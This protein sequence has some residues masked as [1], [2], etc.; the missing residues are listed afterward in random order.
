MQLTP[1]QF[2]PGIVRDATAYTNKGGWFDGNLVR[3]RLGFPE[4]IGGWKRLSGNAFL[5]SCRSMHV[6]FSLNNSRRFAFG[7]HRKYYIE[8]G[9]GLYDIT[10]VR[11]TATLNAPFAAIDGDTQLIVNHPAHG[12]VE[13]AFV[14]FA[15][16]I[17]LGGDITADVLNTEYEIVD[18]I[19][20]D[21]Y[22]IELPI[23]ATSGDTGDG[24]GAVIAQY[25]V[26]PGLDTQV[27]GNG[28]GASP[29]G[30]VGWGLE[31]TFNVDTQLRL[32]TQDNFGEDLIY[33][34]RNGRIF[35]WENAS[36]LT[37]RGVELS[38]LAGADPNT[39]VVATQVL[40]SDRDRHV[41]AFATN[42]I[43]SN[44]QDPMLIRFSDQENALEWTPTATNTAGDIRL[45]SGSRIVRALE[46]KREVLVWTDAALYSMRFIGPPFTFGVEQISQTTTI[47]SFNAFAQAEDAVFW[48]G[49]GT[50]W[51]YSG[52]VQE[53]PCAVREY[54]F[55][56]IN[57]GQSDK[58][59]AGTNTEFSE[60]IWFYPSANS[61]ENNRYVVYNYR[62][63]AW[64]YGEMSRT[65]WLDCC[66]EP[67]PIAAGV[68]NYLYYHEFGL[69]DGSQSPPLPLNSYIE[70]SPIDIAE[71]NNYMMVNR[72]LPDVSFYQSGTNNNSIKPLV[73]M[74]LIAQDFPGANFGNTALVPVERAAKFPVEQFTNQVHVRL[75]TRSVRLRVE[76]NQVGTRWQLGT[77]RVG[78]RPDG[79]R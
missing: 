36:G 59:Y 15:D 55:N 14:T 20:S 57:M 41:I 30:V 77:P 29:W 34:V 60:I 63:Q 28:W 65:A 44:A 52:Q 66:P 13:G 1:L 79:R 64:Y 76:S 6:W 42:P 19:D 45:G 46:T 68:D 33:N 53:L 8:F 31:G 18:I 5:G 9:Q 17:S 67:Y 40:V 51:V 16:A 23:P 3:F 39:P 49:R 72:V 4:S 22:V 74:S 48:M 24:G 2:R 61:D 27:G 56:D 70:S 58:V 12:A 37:T 78:L 43:G 26:N 7:T 25:Q 35:Y 50:F 32:W 11:L 47:I 62:D 75:R 21:S 69:D 10:P 38:T 54:V 71:G 73:N